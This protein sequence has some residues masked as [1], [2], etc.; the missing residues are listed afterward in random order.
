MLTCT[1]GDEAMSAVWSVLKALPCASVTRLP[2][3]V[4]ESCVC[5]GW[6]ALFAERAETRPMVRSSFDSVIGTV[7]D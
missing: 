3:N 6:N 1:P 7:T 5:D 2:L 4:N